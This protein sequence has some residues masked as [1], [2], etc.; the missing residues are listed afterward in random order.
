[1]TNWL[2]EMWQSESGCAV[3]VRYTLDLIDLGKR[4]TVKYLKFLNIDSRLK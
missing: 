3:S 4:K 1:M 2:T